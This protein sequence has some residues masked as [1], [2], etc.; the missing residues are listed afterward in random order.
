ME[1]DVINDFEAVFLP[2]KL[3]EE[4]F[5][6]IPLVWKQAGGSSSLKEGNLRYDNLGV[7]L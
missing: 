4:I 3:N 6:D 1:G 2:G 5:M 7:F